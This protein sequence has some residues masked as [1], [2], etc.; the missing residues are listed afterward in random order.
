MLNPQV[1][2]PLSPPIASSILRA[3]APSAGKPCINTELL[4]LVLS[5]GDHQHSRNDCGQQNQWIQFLQAQGSHPGTSS[6]QHL[7]DDS[8][9]YY[10]THFL[11][12]ETGPQKAGVTQLA[13]SGTR[14]DSSLGPLTKHSRPYSC[15][16]CHR[17]KKSMTG[18]RGSEDLLVGGVGEP[19]FVAWF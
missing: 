8:G 11:E 18:G 10:H 12:G 13:G 4:G 16:S 1:Q 7:L 6:F 5:T 2:L 14:Q 15:R 19:G 9:R 17:R 3:T